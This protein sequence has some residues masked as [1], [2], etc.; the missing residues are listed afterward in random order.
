MRGLRPPLPRAARGGA[1]ASAVR[2]RIRLRPAL[3][4]AAR[5]GTLGGAL[6][7]SSSAGRRQRPR[8]GPRRGSASSCGGLRPLLGGGADE[9]SPLDD[10]VR[11]LV[12]VLSL[13]DFARDQPLRARVDARVAP[14]SRREFREPALVRGVEL[15]RPRADVRRAVGE[16]RRDRLLQE[17]VRL[18]PAEALP[19]PDDQSQPPR[20]EAP[21][22]HAPVLAR[23]FAQLGEEVPGLA[24]VQD[25]S[26]PEVPRL[27]DD[28]HGDDDALEELGDE[29]RRVALELAPELRGQDDEQVRRL[30]HHRAPAVRHLRGERPAELREVRRERV[31]LRR[32]AE[33]QSLHPNHRRDAIRPLAPGVQARRRGVHLATELALGVHVRGPRG[34]ALGDASDQTRRAAVRGIPRGIGER[35]QRGERANAAAARRRGARRAQQRT[36]RL[37]RPERTGTARTRARAAKRRPRGGE[38]RLSLRHI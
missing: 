38:Q 37:L 8:E 26:D 28:L 20:G 2:E 22:L 24:V 4:R 31:P 18:V 27:G 6:R 25:A 12:V 1:S 14:E 23:G 9:R 11:R 13:R 34:V 36:E 21:E 16:H 35:R 7:A 29:V 30:S 15:P 5:L 33:K 19:L 32:A 3:P 10:G 17:F